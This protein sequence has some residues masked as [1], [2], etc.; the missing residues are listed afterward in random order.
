MKAIQ[1][2]IASA[3]K[4]KELVPGMVFT[5]C[6]FQHPILPPLTGLAQLSV[7]CPSASQSLL[8]Q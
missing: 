4:M 2:M 5:F 1:K 3:S 8:Q 6:P 7:R